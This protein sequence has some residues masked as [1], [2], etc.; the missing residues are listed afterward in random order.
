MIDGTGKYVM[1]G[2]INLHLHLRNEPLPLEYVYLLQLATGITTVGPASDRGLDEA[3]TEAEGSARN[4]ILAPRMFPLWSWGGGVSGFTREE[5][6]DPAMAPQIAETMIEVFKTADAEE[7]CTTCGTCQI[8]IQQ[9]T[10]KEP[11]HPMSIIAR[12]MGIDP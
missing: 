12:S 5:L 9:G 2:M 10:G 3:M 4:E 11:V 1:P 8:Q 7:I 6:E